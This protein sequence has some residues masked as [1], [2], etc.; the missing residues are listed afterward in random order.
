MASSLVPGWNSS[1]P[2]SWS[3]LHLSHQLLFPLE[4][5]CFLPLGLHHTLELIWVFQRKEVIKLHQSFQQNSS[6]LPVNNVPP[7]TL[8]SH[9]IFLQHWTFWSEVLKG[10][11]SIF[12]DDSIFYFNCLN[13]IHFKISLYNLHILISFLLLFI[14][15]PF[16]FTAWS[17][18]S[19]VNCSLI[20][21]FTS[22]HLTVLSPPE[23]T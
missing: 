11:A 12:L 3:P 9:P 21:Y 16:L 20:H 18:P 22:Y 1:P 10:L 6:Y 19:L 14:F 15:P 5:F 17:L 23:A 2:P 7:N 13:I 4:I 8:L